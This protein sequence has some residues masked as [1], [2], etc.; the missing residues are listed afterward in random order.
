MQKKAKPSAAVRPSAVEKGGSVVSPD[1]DTTQH[2]H[3]QKNA[4]RSGQAERRG[5]KG[6]GAS[7]DYDN[8]THTHVESFQAERRGQAKRSGE[9]GFGG[10][11]RLRQ[12]NSHDAEEG[13]A[14]RSGQAERSGERGLW[15]PPRLLCSSSFPRAEESQARRPDRAQRSRG[16]LEPPP[17]PD[18]GNP[19]RT[20]TEGGQ[21]E[22]SCQA[23]R[24][25]ELGVRRSPPTA[26]IQ[27][28]RTPKKT[29]PSAAARPSAVEKG[30]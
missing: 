30:G 11:P 15:S 3:A 23:E 2:A 8:L 18:Y 29:K 14:E 6:F 5:K 17:P 16:D 27:G 28:A 24:S 22:R 21:A 25:G 12:S 4:K 20:H 9:G 7:P 13:R 1:Y 19:T 26:A 10:V